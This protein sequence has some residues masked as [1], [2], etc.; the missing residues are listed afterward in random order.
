[1]NKNVDWISAP[2][3]EVMLLEDETEDQILA[4][5]LEES[6]R[7]ALKIRVKPELEHMNVIIKRQYNQLRIN[8]KEC[9]S[10]FSQFIAS[11]NNLHDMRHVRFTNINK[12][13]YNTVL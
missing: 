4:K 11:V 10:K 2:K 3:D 5:A 1:M 12:L 7:Y 6:L 13:Q 8:Y 9:K